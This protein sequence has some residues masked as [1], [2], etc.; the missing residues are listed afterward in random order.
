MVAIKEVMEK[1]DVV[2]VTSRGV[3]IRQHVSDIRVAGRNTQ[4]VRLIKLDQGDLV[5]D[6][7]AVPPDEEEPVNGNGTKDRSDDGGKGGSVP[8]GSADQISLFDAKN[9][10]KKSRRKR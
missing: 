6:V 9:V 8:P 3:I 1:D 4:G 10:T 7:A 2:I 5:A